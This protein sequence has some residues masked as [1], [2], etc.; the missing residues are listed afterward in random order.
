MVN[1]DASL[2]VVAIALILAIPVTFMVANWVRKNVDYGEARFDSESGKVLKD[3]DPQPTGPA[4][5]AQRIETDET[6][7][8][9]TDDE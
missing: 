5:P 2:T 7:E 9:K 3:K 1:T 8:R 6:E 4:V